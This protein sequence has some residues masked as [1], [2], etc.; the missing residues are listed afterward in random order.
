MG[1]IAEMYDEEYERELI[2]QKSRYKQLISYSLEELISLTEE[3]IE[4]GKISD[5]STAAK[6]SLWGKE[7]GFLT[8]KKC[9]SVRTFRNP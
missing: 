4:C 1:D 6:I 8:T 9:F 7:K 3:C 2:A 5:E